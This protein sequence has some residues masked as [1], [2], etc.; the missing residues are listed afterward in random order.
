MRI[1]ADGGYKEKIQVKAL[2]DIL[3]IS[4]IGNYSIK[5]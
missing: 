5:N 4:G 3:M 2:Y 1:E